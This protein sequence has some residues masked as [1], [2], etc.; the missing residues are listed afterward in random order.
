LKILT[1]TTSYFT[2]KYV[3]RANKGVFNY[4]G[5]TQGAYFTHESI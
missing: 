3:L 1:S 5:I 2:H 4:Y